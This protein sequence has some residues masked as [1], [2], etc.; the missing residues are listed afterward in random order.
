MNIN[1][2]QIKTLQKGGLV[3]QEIKNQEPWPPKPNPIHK[4]KK[5]SKKKQAVL[6]ASKDPAHAILLF[7]LFT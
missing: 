4:Y 2:L 1:K 6:I 3:N 7:K 5:L